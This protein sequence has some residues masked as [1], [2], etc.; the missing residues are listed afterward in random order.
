MKDYE[1][2]NIGTEDIEELLLK[3]ETS[4]DIKFVGKE[5]VH[6]TTFGKV[7]KKMTREANFV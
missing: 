5:L 7:V 6:I 2:I 4:F 3:V 1:L